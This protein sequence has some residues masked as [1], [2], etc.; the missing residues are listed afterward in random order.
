MSDKEVG[1]ARR[2]KEIGD[3][4]LELK[5]NRDELNSVIYEKD[6]IIDEILEHLEKING[7]EF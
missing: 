4:E 6:A 3:L 7:S 1:I 5:N 2:L